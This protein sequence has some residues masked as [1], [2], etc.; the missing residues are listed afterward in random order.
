MN[1]VTRLSRLALAGALRRASVFALA[2]SWLG[3]FALAAPITNVIPDT[4]RP[5]PL[6]AVRLT[7]GPLKNAQDLDAKYL[8]ALEPDRMLAGYRIRAGLDLP[9]N[10]ADYCAAYFLHQGMPNHGLGCHEMFRL[11]ENAGAFSL[12]NI[13]CQRKRRAGKSDERDIRFETRP[14]L[15]NRLKNIPERHGGVH[16][17]Q[18]FRLWD[19]TNFP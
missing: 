18:P 6:T 16:L 15:P 2:S 12:E 14:R 7:G 19:D 8:L 5:L 13:S 17:R 10:V 9:V 3:S 1:H 11:G 4:A